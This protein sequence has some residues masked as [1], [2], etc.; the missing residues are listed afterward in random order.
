MAEAKTKPTLQSVDAFIKAQT[1]EKRR[2]DSLSLIKLMEKITKQKAKMW[3]TSI[4]GFGQVHYRYASG[5]EGVASIKLAKD[6]FIFV[7]SMT[8]IPIY[9]KLC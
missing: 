5:H 9:W 3:G 4:V 8:S 1:D 2:K 7:I 6:A